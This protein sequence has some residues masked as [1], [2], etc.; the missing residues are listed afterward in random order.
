MPEF[1]N[2]KYKDKNTKKEFKKPT[3]LETMMQDYP[4]LLFDRPELKIGFTSIVKATIF[5]PVKNDKDSAAKMFTE[6]L[7]PACACSAEFDIF[8]SHREALQAIGV[9]VVDG[10]SAALGGIKVIEGPRVVLDPSIYVTLNQLRQRFTSGAE[11]Y[12]SPNST[13]VIR[14]QQEQQEQPQPR[15]SA[16]FA[17]SGK[18]KV[19]GALE[20][21]VSR[22]G[23]APA[24]DGIAVKN[25]GWVYRPLA[26]DGRK[27]DATMAEEFLAIRGYELLK[28]EATIMPRPTATMP[29]EE[30]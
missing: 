2:P 19:E 22:D 29:K 13:M 14:M 26:A 28:S 18:L 17:L 4:T 3:R 10:G 1:V 9:P 20:V 23:N 27:D 25:R 11:L 8:T 5:S 7:P 15:P 12:L 6:G 16:A 30:L 24:L 21:S